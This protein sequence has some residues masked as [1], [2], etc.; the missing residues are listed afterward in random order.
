VGSDYG[1]STVAYKFYEAEAI[2]HDKALLEDLET[3]L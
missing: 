2:S 3:V 1:S